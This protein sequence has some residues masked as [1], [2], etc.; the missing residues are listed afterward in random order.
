MTYQQPDI[1]TRTGDWLVDTVRRKPEALLLL[2]A[3]CALLMRSGRRP[4]GSIAARMATSD[5][6]RREPHRTAGRS[7]SSSHL[8]EG[9]GQAAEY[10]GDVA[11]KVSSTAKAYASNVADTVTNY[12]ETARRTVSD[13]AEE[14]RQ[15]ASHYADDARRNISETSDRLITQAETT[16]RTAAEAIREQPLLVAAFGLAA[17]AAVATFFPATD[18]ERRTLGAASDALAEKAAKT[19]ENLLGAAGRAGE[20]LKETVAEHGLDS[21]GLK[22]MAREVAG[23]FASAAAGKTE[24]ERSPSDRGTQ[25]SETGASGPTGRESDLSRSFSGPRSQSSDAD[26]SY[27]SGRSAEDARS[28]E[29]KGRQTGKRSSGNVPG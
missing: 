29:A 4:V 13:Y 2:V 27:V 10:A 11:D 21:E 6:G 19:G 24:Q 26:A 18:I 8:R 16:Y 15:S 23:T 1:Y 9:A 3:G 22:D 12:A 5:Q 14:A 20:R 25:S 28:T 7:P 17:G